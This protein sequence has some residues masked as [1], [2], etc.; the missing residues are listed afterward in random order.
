[1][2]R[3]IFLA[4][5]LLVLGIVAQA[6]AQKFTVGV[7]LA[8][9][10]NPFYINMRKGMEVKAKELGVKLR[11]VTANEDV[12]KQLNGV[13]D[14]IATRVNLI[15]I[16]PIDA[17]A[18]T[19]AYEAA[20]KAGIPIMSIA[21]VANNRF[22]KA[23]IKVDE[24]WGG[25]ITGEWLVKK[26]G[27][28]WKVA[29]LGGPAGASFARN[30]RNGFKSAIKGRPGIEIVFEQFSPLT[31][32]HGLKLAEDAL[33]RSPDIKAIFCANDE[34]ALGAVHAIEAARKP[35][36]LVTGYNGVPP[37]IKAIAKGRMAHTVLLRSMTWGK[38]GVQTAYDYLKGRKIPK[39]VI[40]PSEG[41][42][43]EKA[44]KM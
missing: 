39:Q 37:A 3:L 28:K 5:L 27:S 20:S 36:I 35:G 41:I 9:D 38:F 42:D 1:M 15:L 30:L 17:R 43:K 6:G 21:R 25:K 13:Q 22:E 18:A 40:V 2:K 7:S 26:L 19:P 44:N 16:S 31:R 10:T 4:S 11:F 24:F 34:L 12:A 8:S 23:Q 33:T 29:I 14:L 32:E